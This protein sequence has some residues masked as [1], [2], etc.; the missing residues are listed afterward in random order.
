MSSTAAAAIRKAST[1]VSEL[2]K[3]TTLNRTIDS[4]KP[5][6]SRENKATS[7][8]ADSDKTPNRPKGSN[9]NR[10]A[11]MY[12]DEDVNT[13]KPKLE[14]IISRDMD[15]IEREKDEH[16]AKKKDSHKKPISREEKS[17]KKMEASSSKYNLF[18]DMDEKKDSDG[19]ANK[20]KPKAADQ[21]TTTTSL[22]LSQS[23]ESETAGST[24]DNN[25]A[26]PKIMKK[27]RSSSNDRSEE[28]P[29]K[30]NKAQPSPATAPVHLPKPTPPPSQQPIQSPVPSTAPT[31]PSPSPSNEQKVPLYK[32]LQGVT[33]AISGIQ[34]IFTRKQNCIAYDLHIFHLFRIRNEVKFGKRAWKWVPNTEPIGMIVVHI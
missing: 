11:L 13:S 1:T 16:S 32:L 33:F 22:N 19:S 25:M 6:P 10:D 9:R 2:K 27:R 12:D 31:A 24:D 4:P 3:C 23:D 5:S 26:T 15:R 17:R 18:L 20:E 8:N 21:P 30:R 7:N 28:T 29:N 14:Q 34:V